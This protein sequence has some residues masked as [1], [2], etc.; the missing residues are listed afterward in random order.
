M[1][2]FKA[3]VS[4]INKFLSRFQTHF[5]KKQFHI[6]TIIIYAFFLEY[7]RFSLQALAVKTKTDYE[8]IQ[9]FFSDSDWDSTVLNATRLQFLQTMRT[10]AAT[11]DGALIIDDTAAPKIYAK[12]TEGAQL[13]YCG[14]LKREA[15]CNVVVNSAFASPKKRFPVDFRFYKPAA[16]FPLE[17]HDPN[18]KTKI[19]LAQELIDSASAY[20][21]PFSMILTDAWYTSAADFLNFMHQKKLSF[22]G[23]IKDNRNI[24]LYH[25]V[26]KKR[27]ALKQDE[28]VTLIRCHFWHQVKPV[29]FVSK[30]GTRVALMTY[31]FSAQLQGCSIPLKFLVILGPWSL[32][33]EKSIHILIT[34]Q[35]NLSRHKIISFWK[36]RWGI[37]RIFQEL[38]DATFF[39]QYQVRHKNKIERH[40]CLSIMAWS[41]LYWIKQNA[42]LHKI[43]AVQ[44]GSFN[45]YKAALAKMIAFSDALQLS[46]NKFAAA[47]SLGIIS[48]RFAKAA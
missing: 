21:L 6:F 43:F 39:D 27:V 3:N 41:A 38:K 9:Y 28:L 20:N 22:I 7:K 47:Q 14:V 40:W 33:D 8:A 23:E 4:V 25:P 46:K 42:Y 12:K 48:K 32:D 36:L 10:C 37:E 16:E 44:P 1:A 2:P 18:F 13:Q 17:Q 31:T 35:L 24:L 19:Q 26:H 11:P 5:S 30:D 45:E 34:N 29:S 15:V